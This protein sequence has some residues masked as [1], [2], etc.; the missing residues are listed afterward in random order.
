VHALDKREKEWR[1]GKERVR[2]EIP[3]LAVQILDERLIRP[4]VVRNCGGRV[5]FG[6]LLPLKKFGQ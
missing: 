3:W 4:D 1:K 5:A 6:G 2:I